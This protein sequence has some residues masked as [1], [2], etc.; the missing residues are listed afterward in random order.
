MNSKQELD[1]VIPE[2][3]KVLD[4]QLTLWVARHSLSPARVNA[5]RQMVVEKM[6]SSVTVLP[7]EWWENL[8]RSLRS[9]SQVSLHLGS[10]SELCCITTTTASVG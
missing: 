2:S 8:I 6:E 4:Q 5:I 10:I 3:D 1:H 7:L 9:A